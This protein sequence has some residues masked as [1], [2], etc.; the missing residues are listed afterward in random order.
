MHT[1]HWLCASDI[2]SGSTYT[3]TCPVTETV[4]GP[5]TTY[6]KVYTT[7]SVIKVREPNVD[8]HRLNEALTD[9]DYRTNHCNS[10]YSGSNILHQLGSC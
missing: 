5:G 7:T 4:T 10:D 8:H 3:T 6:T 9:P 1:Y 2:D